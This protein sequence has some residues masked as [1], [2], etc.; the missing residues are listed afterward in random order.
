M[1]NPFRRKTEALADSVAA[2]GAGGFGWDGIDADLEGYRAVGAGRREIP[3]FTAEKARTLSVHAYRTNPMARAILDT[4]T[5]FCVGDSGVS[6]SCTSPE[7]E[8]IARAFWTDP[9]NKCEDTQE[10]MLRSH[11]LLG[12]TALELM[13]GEQSGFVRYAYVTPEAIKKIDTEH[14]NP[15]WPSKMWIS[16]HGGGDMSLDIVQIDDITGLREGDGMF[17]ADWRALVTDRRGSPF[18]SPVLDWLDAY[19][20]VLWNLIDRTA[21]ARYL[22]WDVQIDGDDDAVKKFIAD[23]KGLH[24]PRSGTLEVHNEKVTWT[25]KTADAG[26]FEDKQTGQMAMTNLAAGAGLAKTWLAE[27]E[28]ANR[29]TSLTMAEPVR[30][31]VGGVQKLWLGH[32]TELVRF[33]V[34][35]AVAHG[36]LPQMVQVINAAGDA[37]PVPAADT[38]RVVGPE[39]A[40]SDAKVNADIL[41]S[42]SQALTGMV[43][44][45]LLS[46]DAASVAA[47]KAWEGFMG[48]P[49][50]HDLDHD[51]DVDAIEEYLDEVTAAA[52]ESE[53]ASRFD[54]V[55]ADRFPPPAPEVHVTVNTPEQKHEHTI[56]APVVN[57]HTTE[58]QQST[59]T[60]PDVIVNPTPVNVHVSPTP[61][62]F[63]VEPPNVSVTNQVPVPSVTVKTQPP[64][65]AVPDV[66]VNVEAP[67]TPTR[68]T[69]KRDRSG[70]ITETI[71]GPA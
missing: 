32:M 26:A 30:R 36:R 24:A 21:L 41:V 57:V 25:A 12:E 29:A 62:S 49:Y 67:R 42:L 66:V 61:V 68:T 59:Q 56:T 31:R 28:D 22:V 18:L 70:N 27:P 17:W 71:T 46:K 58:A 33:A 40:A 45:N 2:S 15:L 34:D 47:K 3:R 4:Y 8:P 60:L 14:N 5:S 7:V 54:R 13:T 48:I 19:D 51:G 52:Q 37:V 6:L 35:Q 23:R 53:R 38:V 65:V 10:V 11:M 43:A 1:R 16:Q 69:I 50:S 64:A 63:N 9:R 55:I 44:S 39:I 20:Q